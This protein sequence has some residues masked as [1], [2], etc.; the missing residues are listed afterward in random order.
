MPGLR[1]LAGDEKWDVKVCL[2]EVKSDPENFEV[3]IAWSRL[4]PLRSAETG[5]VNN[6]SIKKTCGC[7][8]KGRNHAF[9]DNVCQCKSLR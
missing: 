4:T 2:W 3:F 1:K 6:M 8:V 7:S 9:R 5:M